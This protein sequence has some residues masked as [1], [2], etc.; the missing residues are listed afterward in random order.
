VLHHGNIT[1]TAH[2]LLF[3]IVACAVSV[4]IES[5]F[6]PSE[7]RFTDYRTWSETARKKSDISQHGKGGDKTLTLVEARFDPVKDYVAFLR[8]SARERSY[9]PCELFKTIVK[10]WRRGLTRVRLA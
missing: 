5:V 6:H 8:F 4:R 7:N 3:Q 2:R 10:I 1:K 9:R